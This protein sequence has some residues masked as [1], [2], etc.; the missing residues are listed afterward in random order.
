[1][2]KKQQ[3]NTNNHIVI[4]RNEFVHEYASWVFS[5]NI[6][7]NNE[8]LVS[9]LKIPREITNPRKNLELFLHFIARY[10]RIECKGNKNNP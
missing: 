6:D 3:I 5:W 7:Y 10:W 2:S 1:M 9:Y 4:P 8:T